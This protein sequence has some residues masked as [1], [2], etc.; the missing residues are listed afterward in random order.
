MESLHWEHS[1]KASAKSPFS[2][3]VLHAN[4]CI[5]IVAPLAFGADKCCAEHMCPDLTVE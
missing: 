4:I 2:C 3:A 5:N 1:Q